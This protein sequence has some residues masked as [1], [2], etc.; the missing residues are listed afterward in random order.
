M[1]AGAGVAQ[2]AA[3]VAPFAAAFA[4]APFAAAPLAHDP[5]S[6][7]RVDE[8]ECSVTITALPSGDIPPIWLEYFFRWIEAAC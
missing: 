3:N 7:P 5:G 2:V 6:A 4:P 1:A 8:Y